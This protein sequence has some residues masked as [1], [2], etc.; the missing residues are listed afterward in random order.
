MKVQVRSVRLIAAATLSLVL[1]AC[2]T[3]EGGSNELGF[4]ISEDATPRSV[5]LPAYPGATPY[6]GDDDSSGAD[7]GI[8]LPFFGLKVVAVELETTDEPKKVAAFYREA[9]AK[10][11]DVVQCDDGARRD[12]WLGKR[13]RS[14]GDDA[15]K[16]NDD[17]P[18]SH[19]VVYKV[20]TEKNQRV[21][22]IKPL[23]E[24]TQFNLV[25]VNVRD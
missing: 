10:Y 8:S 24:G 2:S 22:A 12:E 16:C 3:G 15:L 11:G 4:Q 6:K 1:G 21:V 23:G 9:M 7:I 19:F 14:E 25:Y 20:G 5:G 17:E 13:D 18:G